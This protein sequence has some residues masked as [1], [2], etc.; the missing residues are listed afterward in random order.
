MNQ[1]IE[2]TEESEWPEEEDDEFVPSLSP[3]D[4]TAYHEASH[5]VAAV[6]LGVKFDYVEIR[7]YQHTARLGDIVGGLHLTPEFADL[8]TKDPANADDRTK[9][10]KLAIVAIAGE[11]GQAILEQRACDLRLP[12]AEGDYEIVTRLADWL[13]TDPADRDAFIERQT[14]A[15]CELV[16][17]PLCYQQVECLADQLKLPLELSYNSV[18]YWM[19]LISESGDY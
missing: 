19:K 15:A 11:A 13:Y 16:S 3:Y 1:P 6:N 17:D 18:L 10:E 4:V 12:S 7:L 5:A 8:R 14:V 9:V 2:Q